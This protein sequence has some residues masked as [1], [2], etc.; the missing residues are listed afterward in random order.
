MVQL[1]YFAECDEATRNQV[2]A[3][4]RTKEFVHRM[5]NSRFAE[6]V[7]DKG[8]DSGH[9]NWVIF[10]GQQPVGLVAASVQDR[11]YRNLLGHEPDDPA[12]YPLLGTGTYIAPQYRCRGYATAAKRAIV[13]HDAARSVRAFGCVV[14]ADNA[15]SLKSITKA[16]YV[17]VGVDRKSGQ[18]DNIRFRL[19]LELDRASAGE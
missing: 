19:R 1:R 9:H 2:I 12:D 13:E 7:L 11:P 16:G 3:W 15:A 8:P 17:R 6:T 5:G 14:A 10:D 4:T 18:P